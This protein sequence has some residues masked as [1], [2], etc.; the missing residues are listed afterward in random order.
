MN[1]V[2]IGYDPK[3]DTA[4]EVLKNTIQRISG[5]NAPRIV[6]LKKDI[7]EHIGVYTRKSELIHGQPYDIIDGRPFSTEFSFTRF[8]VPALNLYEGKALFM[9]SDMYIRADIN[10]LFDICNM[11]YY[12]VYCVHHK[13][14]P[15]KTTKMD[16]KEQQPYRRKNWSSLMMFN[17]SHALNKQLTPEVVNTQTGRWLH[18]FGW[19]PDKEADIGRIPEEWNWLDGHSDP[20]LDAKNVHFTT[21]G[22]WFNKWSPR[23]AIEGKYAVEWCNEADYLKIK[24]IIQMDKDY[25]I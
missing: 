3:E 20:E 16:G 17:C 19:L 22:P 1:T 9:D 23:G 11:D 15:E 24:G 6:P 14:E 25:M 7:L 8:L 5:K 12:P 21:G 10:E 13:Y 2:Y 4:Y 18:G